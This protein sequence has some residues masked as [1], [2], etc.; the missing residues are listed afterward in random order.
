MAFVSLFALGL[1]PSVAQAQPNDNQLVAN[2]ANIQKANGEQL[3]LQEFAA[4]YQKSDSPAKRISS[5]ELNKRLAAG[6][7]L[8]LLDAR[9]REEYEVSHIHQA[10]RIG[11]EDFSTERIWMLKRQAPI[12]IYCAAGERS[13]ITAD[14][15]RALGFSDVAV[16]EES[17]IGWSNADL[18]LY[19]SK[20]AKTPQIHIHKKENNSLLK[21]GRPV[22]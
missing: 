1:L 19:T 4:A 9:S 16:L 14:Y 13:Y 21:K 7:R 10:R 12:V 2:N 22:W 8:A 3:T 17:L 20:N 11:F 6:E 5:A 18:P 15:L